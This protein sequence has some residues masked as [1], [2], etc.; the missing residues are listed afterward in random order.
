MR[1][2][3]VSDDPVVDFAG[4]VA[5]TMKDLSSSHVYFVMQQAFGE[6]DWRDCEK[7]LT[8]VIKRTVP[9][10]LLP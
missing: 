7:I 3:Q 6:I 8:E 4:R 9:A 1:Q 2:R 10:E 5:R